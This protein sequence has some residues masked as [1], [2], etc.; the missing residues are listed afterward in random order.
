MPSLLKES[1]SRKFFIQQRPALNATAEPQTERQTLSGWELVP[2]LAVECAQAHCKI[3]RVVEPQHIDT[4]AC[5]SHCVAIEL[6]N[7]ELLFI[8]LFL[9][10]FFLGGG[11]TYWL[12]CSCTTQHEDSVEAA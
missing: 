10:Y 11:D 12:T 4:A 3:P 7:A 9:F 5:Q 6:H 2:A 1:N 8:F